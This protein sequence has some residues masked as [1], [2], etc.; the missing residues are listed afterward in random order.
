MK[1]YV[2]A[3]F[4]INDR[5]TFNQYLSR[6]GDTVDKYDGKFLVRGPIANVIEG[7]P[8]KFLAIVEF[9]SAQVAET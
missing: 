2:V 7:E 8:H 6:V 1:G 9:P 3:N 5:N 4:T